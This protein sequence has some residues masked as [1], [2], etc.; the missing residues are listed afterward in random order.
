MQTKPK[1]APVVCH[2]HTRPVVDIQYSNI[3]P[4]GYF[5]A[6]AS[7]DAA[8]MLRHGDS[9]D[10]YGTFQGHKGAVWACVLNQQALLC[11]TASGD[12]SARIWDA[13][14]GNQLHE[15]PHSHIVRSA[16]FSHANK[17]ATGG[18]EKVIRIYD[19]DKVEEPDLF[20]AQSHSIRCLAWLADDNT[21][22][23]SYSDLPGIGVIDVRSKQLIKTLET[24]SPVQSIEIS[25]DGKHM[26]TAEGTAVRIWD[27][28]SLT[29]Q[30][31]HRFKHP[32]AESASYCA[33]RGVFA[34]G[35]AD[36][37]VRLFNAESG[38]ELECNKG[39][40]G[41]VHAVRFS[42]TYDSYA[43]G[44][45]DGTIRIWYVDGSN[46]G[47]APPTNGATH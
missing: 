26:T 32:N 31:V 11:A 18:Q 20:P 9:G 21:M 13:C 41:P 42:P 2:G 33:A 8:P 25:F 12:F 46:G 15:L 44:S 23:C 4:D 17:L 29:Q 1:R 7:K 47:G 38:E 28:S 27:T 14:S 45:E 34:A 30:R 35:G 19:V 3:T 36:M 6:S 40:H 16:A 24:E 22:L 39:H 5:L 37:W 10:W 43:S